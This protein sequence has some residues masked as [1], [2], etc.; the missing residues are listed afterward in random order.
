MTARQRGRLAL[1]G[2]L[3]AAVALA[4]AAEEGVEQRARAIKSP[5]SQRGWEKIPWQTD[6]TEGLRI[7][8]EESRPIFLWATG[9][10]PLER[11]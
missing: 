9:D 4:A 1:A 11:C 8:R 3:L 5:A 7:A 2:T 6:L 10:D